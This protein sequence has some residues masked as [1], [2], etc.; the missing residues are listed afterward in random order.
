M[1][2]CYKSYHT[3]EQ[4]D[5]DVFKATEALAFPSL[6]QG[7]NQRM[8]DSPINNYDKDFKVNFESVLGPNYSDSELGLMYFSMNDEKYIY[9]PYDV[10]NN[11]SIKYTFNKIL[12]KA[13]YVTEINMPKYL[14]MLYA[15]WKEYNPIS[16]Y[17]M[18]E[19]SI[20]ASKDSKQI[21]AVQGEAYSEIHSDYKDPDKNV[22][23]TYTF[24][25]D[26]TDETESAGRLDSIT[27]TT[28]AG[29]SYNKT[30]YSGTDNDGKEVG[31]TTTI[32]H[33]NDSETNQKLDQ[34]DKLKGDHTTDHIMDR[35]G[36]I[37]VTTT[38][39]MLESEIAL[40]S[41]SVLEELFKDLNEEL[42]L[43]IF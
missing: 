6:L 33:S 21:T 35:S 25:Y 39:Q 18:I 19:H 4:F 5:Q 13:K 32:S 12:L 40:K 29:T 23:K 8:I 7:L 15:I 34:D 22:S 10:D 43:K 31:V 2:N 3:L 26:N 41:K 42:T 38:Q 9:I 1:L 20:D 14:A 36:N 27:H 30:L 24:P 17:D 28:S 37:G 11:E 16:N